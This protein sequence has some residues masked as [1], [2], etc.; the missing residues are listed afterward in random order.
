[1]SDTDDDNEDG[2]HITRGVPIAL[3]V[4]LV[5]MFV[6]QIVTAAWFAAR[7]DGRV[8]AL[9]KAQLTFSPQAERLTRVEEKLENV[10]TG[11]ADIKII[12]QAREPK[13]R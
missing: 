6:T 3:I 2:W 1:M 5:V 7:L 9:E 10:K 11:I 8:D 4:T 12:L 13:P